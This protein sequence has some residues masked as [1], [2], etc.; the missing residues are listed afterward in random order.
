LS[1]D[2]RFTHEASDDLERLFMFLAEN[3]LDAAVRAI[4]AIRKGVQL[5]GEFPFACPKVDENNPLLREILIAF[6]NAGYVALYEIE[7]ETITVLAVRHQ[8]EADYY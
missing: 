3:D 2:V 1:W 5:L 6:G 8:R 7:S 4:E